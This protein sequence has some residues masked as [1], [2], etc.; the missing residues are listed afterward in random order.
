MANC[1][2]HRVSEK[3]TGREMPASR[4]GKVG[5]NI[6]SEKEAA[7]EVKARAAGEAD[8]APNCLRS[9]CISQ[10]LQHQVK[11]TT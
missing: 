4:G 8:G 5:I 3:S 10:L 11:G 6:K 1:C 2:Y 7:V 9:L